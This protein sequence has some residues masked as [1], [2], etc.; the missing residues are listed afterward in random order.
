MRKHLI[1]LEEN[2]LQFLDI[3]FVKFLKMSVSKFELNELKSVVLEAAK[4]PKNILLFTL[5]AGSSFLLY[6]VLKIYLL[7]RKFRHIPGPPTKGYSKRNFTK[8]IDF[9]LILLTKIELRDFSEEIILI[10]CKPT[11]KNVFLSSS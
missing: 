8:F 9:L 3:E 1:K 11:E 7:R 10:L 2:F 5:G 6:Q 4:K